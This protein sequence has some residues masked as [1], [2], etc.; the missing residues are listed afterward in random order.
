MEGKE[1]GHVVISIRT[2]PHVADSKIH[3]RRDHFCRVLAVLHMNTDPNGI[4]EIIG[5]DGRRGGSARRWQPDP[6]GH[7]PAGR[8]EKTPQSRAGCNSG[9]DETLAP[10]LDLRF[11]N[12]LFSERPDH[13]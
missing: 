4:E 3:Q 5:A 2:I 10:F 8:P 13:F 6:R 11:H 9:W 12:R 1:A 7:E